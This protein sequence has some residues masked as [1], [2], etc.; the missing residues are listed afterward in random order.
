[1]LIYVL[2]FWI[3]TQLNAPMWFWWVFGLG[4]FT[5]IV[6]FGIDMLKIGRDW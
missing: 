3:G 2:I 5:R 4:I 6:S 1:M